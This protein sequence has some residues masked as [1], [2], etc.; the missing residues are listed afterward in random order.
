MKL[1]SPLVFLA[2]CDKIAP[3]DKI[4]DTFILIDRFIIGYMQL[5]LYH[6]GKVAGLLVDCILKCFREGRICK[7]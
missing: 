1:R 6:I 2:P 3:S 7:F 4:L 5:S